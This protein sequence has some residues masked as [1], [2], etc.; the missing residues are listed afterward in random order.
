MKRIALV[1]AAGL[2][3]TS[4]VLLLSVALHSGGAHAATPTPTSTPTLPPVPHYECYEILG[5]P[6]P[7]PVPP[8]ELVTQFGV[9]TAVPVL[10]PNRLCLPAL[11]NDEGNMTDSH[12]ECFSIAGPEPSRIVD[13]RTQFGATRN[14]AVGP[15]EELCMPVS[16]VIAPGPTPPE[17]S[18]VPH[19]KCYDI[20]G[21]APTVSPVKLQTQFRTETGVTVGQPTRLCLPAIKNGEGSLAVPHLE[22]FSITGPISGRTVNLRTQFGTTMMVAIGAP[23]ELCVPAIKD[24]V[25]RGVGGE[26]GLP[27]TA[28]AAAE[29]ANPTAE[30]SSPPYVVIAGAVAAAVALAVLTGGW[31]A[32]RRWLK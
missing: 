6:T 9:E 1:F 24:L 5:S 27:D 16:K 21:T 11:K 26:Q 25:V 32:R 17:P 23:K 29:A 22:C 20:Q 31:Y 10:A 8:V 13:L 19:Y 28:P 12:L 7:P 14:V 4:M 30:S 3:A 15:P 2:T 18:P